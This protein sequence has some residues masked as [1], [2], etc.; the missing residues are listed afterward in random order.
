MI[1]Q[2]CYQKRLFVKSMKVHWKWNFVFRSLLRRSST[3]PHFVR[4][5]VLL[6]WTVFTEKWPLIGTDESLSVALWCRSCNQGVSSN[7][8]FHGCYLLAKLKLDKKSLLLAIDPKW[9]CTE[10]WRCECTVWGGVTGSHRNMVYRVV[11]SCSVTGIPDV[12]V[13]RRLTFWYKRLDLS[14]LHL[15]QVADCSLS[16]NDSEALLNCKYH[17]CTIPY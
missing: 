11:F 1:G 6:Q 17:E 3:K 2:V 7:C 16:P 9:C 13:H 15:Q 14:H 10:I 5:S 8:N 4:Q 12:S